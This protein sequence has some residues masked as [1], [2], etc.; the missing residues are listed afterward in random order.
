MFSPLSRLCRQLSQRESQVSVAAFL[1]FQIQQGILHGDA[2]GVAGEL[3]VAAQ[4]SVT[5]DNYPNRIP[6]AGHAHGSG[7]FFVADGMGNVSVGPGFPVGDPGEFLPDGNL[8]GR[9]F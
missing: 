9:T 6:V 4:N 8:K 1:S 5:G 2:A 3:P 7:G